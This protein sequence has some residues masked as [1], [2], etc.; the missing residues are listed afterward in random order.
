MKFDRRLIY[1]FDWTLLVL[2]LLISFI[3]LVNIYSAGFRSFAG[4]E[5]LYIRQAQ[6]VLLGLVFMG[7]AFSIDYRLISRYAY[8]IYGISVVLLFIVFLFGYATRGSQRWIVLA[9]FSFQPS[10]LVKLT[11]ILALARYFDDHRS[12]TAYRLRELLIPSLIVLVPFLS[13][14]RQ[15]DL[16]TALIVLILFVSMIFFVGIQWRSLLIS[17]AAT[18]IL[19]P[20][21]WFFLH[22]YQKERILTFFNPERDPLGTGYHIIQSMIAVGSGG[23]LGKGFLKGTQTQLKFLPEQQTDFVFSVFAEEW[24]FLGCLVLMVLFLTLILWGLKIAIH[25]RDYLGTLVAF[26]I[27]TII[28]SEVF[29]NI[30]MVLAILPVV[31]IPLP[32]LSYG[33]S[34]MVILMMAVG[35]LMNISM[36]RFLLQP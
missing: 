1:H 7:L 3:G 30:G 17:L 14:V 31:G 35:L 5:N 11:I 22:D 16:G 33:G 36:R 25:S 28:F 2:V 21:G 4:Q 12:G 8:V 32:F 23:I 18:I 34:A 20:L 19:L 26:G 9:G 10:E 13:I 29:I 27:T 24:G 15:P 6:W